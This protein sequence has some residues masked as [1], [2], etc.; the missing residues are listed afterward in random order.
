MNSDVH[1]DESSAGTLV[2]VESSGDSRSAHLEHFEEMVAAGATLPLDEAFFT[3]SAALRSGVAV[4]DQ[5]VRLDEIASEV[6][7]PTIEG[8][9]RHLFSG[10]LPF[11]GNTNDYYDPLNSLLDAVLDR[12]LGI[13]ISLSV[14]TIEIGR[15]LGV[16]LSGVAMPGHF[17]VGSAVE[18]GKVP[19]RFIDPF[20]GGAMFDIDGCRQLFTEV[21]GRQADFDPRFV[22]AVHP[23]AILDRALSNLK[24]L[25]SSTQD[26]Q[27]LRTVMAL[28]A[29]I[30]GIGSVEADEF[31]QM[32]AP[33]N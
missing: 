32:M 22:A 9:V 33:L 11:R 1:A 25:Y 7:S 30:P 23:L 20:H 31:R 10:E 27:N 12:R 13:P 28:R 26:L 8:V 29:R 21:V 17:L 18:F 4:L 24:A 15:R 19:D 5:L 6:E 2:D 14:L 3:I 16:Q